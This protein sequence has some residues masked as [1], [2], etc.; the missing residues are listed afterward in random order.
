MV[1]TYTSVMAILTCL[2]CLSA[3][4]AAPLRLYVATDG[5]DAWSGRLSAANSQHSDG[6]FAT[7]ERARDEIRAQKKAGCLDSGAVV[8]VRA[9]AYYLNKPF[10]LTAED[11]GAPAAPVVYRAA[12]KGKATLVGGKIVKGF[13]PYQGAIMQLDLKPLGLAEKPLTQLFFNG[14]R[15]TLARWPNRDPNDIHGGE[16]AYIAAAREPESKRSFQYSGDRPNRWAHPEDARVSIWPNYNWW[17]TIIGIEK[18]DRETS[19]ITLAGDLGYS[20]QRGR[21]YFYQNIFEELDAPGEWF[22]DKRSGALYFWPPSPIDKG[23][24]IVPTL[25]SVVEIEGAAHVSVR[26]FAIQCCN[27]NAVTVS[28]GSDCL[29]A[30]NTVRNTGGWGIVISGGANNGAVGNDI[31]ATGQGGISL[32]GGDRKTLTPGGNYA[33]NNH[34]HHFANIYPT[35]NTGVA[36]NGVGNRVS[37]NLIHDAPHIGIIL[38]GNENVIEYNELHHLCFEGAD[39]G[40]YYMGRDWTQRGNLLRYNKF[41]DIY[42][43]GLADEP[44]AEGVCHYDSP[45]WAWAVYLDDCS[46]GTTIYGNVIY[47]VPLCGVMVGGGRDNLVENNIFVEC[48]PAYHIDARWDAYPWGYMHELLDAMNYRQPPYSE[49]YPELLT[50]GDDPRT[51][52]NNKF[53]RNVVSY[54]RDDIAGLG[55]THPSEGAAILYDLSPFDPDTCIFDHNTIYHFGAPIRVQASFY[56]QEGG[57]RL[58]WDEWRSRGFD[59]NSI[60]ADPLFV[61][62]ERDDYQLRPE[63]PAFKQGFKRIPMQKIGLYRSSLRASWPAPPDDRKSGADITRQ[64]VK[65]PPPGK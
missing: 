28:G 27:A 33:D 18:I 50:M 20:L 6:P 5:N 29:V 55:S 65:V 8:E 21:R 47:R 11:S 54:R 64:T 9:G 56:K 61:D 51:P 31:Y 1:L 32:A 62:P 44:D 35:Y 53:L 60:I 34:I 49:R 23:A 2:A 58:A 15:M 26:G 57:G 63:S 7:L 14:E 45:L 46:S 52:A 59:K 48:I 40:G 17:Q 30:A 12:R 39:N 41:H 10:K 4:A 43:Y 25:D 37:H 19:T 3:A 24:V 13:K 22:F 42:G 36:I 16:W 38:S